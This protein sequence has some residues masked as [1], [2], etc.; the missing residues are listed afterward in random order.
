MGESVFHGVTYL[1]AVLLVGNIVCVG[2][3]SVRRRSLAE[4]C[5][6]LC[7]RKSLKVHSTAGSSMGVNKDLIRFNQF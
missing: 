7:E 4:G 2:C 1:K 5:S 3:E 6:S